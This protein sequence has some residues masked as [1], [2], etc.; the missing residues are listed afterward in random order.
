MIILSVLQLG[1]LSQSL[2]VR[3]TYFFASSLLMPYRGAALLNRI[4]YNNGGE[5]RKSF[6]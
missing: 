4:N 1:V 3:V 5:E 6:T 2:E